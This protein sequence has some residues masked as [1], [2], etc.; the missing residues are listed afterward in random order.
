MSDNGTWWTARKPCYFRV[1]SYQSLVQ[2]IG[3][4][5][6]HWTVESHRFFNPI[7]IPLLVSNLLFINWEYT[8]QTLL[9]SYTIDGQILFPPYISVCLSYCVHRV[10]HHLSTPMQKFVHYIRVWLFSFFVHDFILLIDLLWFIFVL[11]YYWKE[12]R[13]LSF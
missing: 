2:T 5:H 9:T 11:T 4:W 3:L 12:S 10:C 7:H 8:N 13:H 1:S 6:D